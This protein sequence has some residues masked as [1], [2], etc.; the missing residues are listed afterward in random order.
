MICPPPSSPFTKFLRMADAAQNRVQSS[1]MELVQ[2]LDRSY[3]RKMELRM[4]QCA[5]ECCSN[6]EA[7]MEKVHNCVRKCSDET[8]RAQT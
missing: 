4:H 8:E 6:E 7:P 3:L 2:R 5:I 1:I